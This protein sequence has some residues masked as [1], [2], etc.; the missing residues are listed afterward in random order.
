[1]LTN[2]RTGKGNPV[3]LTLTGLAGR[4]GVVGIP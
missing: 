1:M 4:V 2:N 3:T